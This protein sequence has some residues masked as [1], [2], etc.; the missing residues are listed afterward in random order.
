[1]GIHF[2]QLNYKVSLRRR[3]V[4]VVVVWLT[5]FVAVSGQASSG[6]RQCK[7]VYFSHPKTK[8]IEYGGIRYEVP[9][10]KGTG[11]KLTPSPRAVSFDTRTPVVQSI[12][13]V[14]SLAE[15]DRPRWPVPIK[16]LEA[17]SLFSQSSSLRALELP[18]KLPT[19]EVLVPA[20]FAQFK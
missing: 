11:F 16:A 20:E 1:M 10:F 6:L 4:E 7:N 19:S 8:A 15:F 3:F 5:I 13:K 17:Q 18:I 14:W 12:A 9:I 2:P